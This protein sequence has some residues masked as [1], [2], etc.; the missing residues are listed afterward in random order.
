MKAYCKIDD[1]VLN[2][3]G[4]KFAECSS[5]SQGKFLLIFSCYKFF[6]KISKT[7]NFICGSFKLMLK[8]RREAIRSLS[9]RLYLFKKIHNQN[10]IFIKVFDLSPQ[11]FIN[12]VIPPF[13]FIEHLDKFPKIPLK[14]FTR[15]KLIHKNFLKYLNIFP[16]HRV[17]SFPLI[18]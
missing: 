9:L 2:Y 5:S 4:E 11:T 15:K 6:C 10:K 14:I 13:V 12:I 8:V 17:K 16:K 7:S 1:V 3:F 18:S